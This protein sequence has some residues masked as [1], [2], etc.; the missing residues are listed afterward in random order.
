MRASL[1][2]VELTPLTRDA[3]FADP[4]PTPTLDY[5]RHSILT[6]CAGSWISRRWIFWGV[7]QIELYS[8]SGG[9]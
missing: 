4:E 1:D 8:T 2:F 3:H 7:T 9:V 5:N 6:A